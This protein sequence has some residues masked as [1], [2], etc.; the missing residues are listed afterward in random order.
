[1]ICILTSGLR[2]HSAELGVRDGADDGEEAA[3]HPHD[4]GAPD[5]AGLLDDSL[6]RD[7]DARADDQADQQRDA[8]G[9]AKIL[10]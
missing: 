3:R 2:D 10:F 7:E 6:G 9:Q 4:Q 8:V 5:G 1:V